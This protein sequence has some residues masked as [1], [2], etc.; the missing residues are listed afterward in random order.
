MLLKLPRKEYFTEKLFR[1]EGLLTGSNW[2]TFTAS[3]L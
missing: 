1:D 3:T 2:Y